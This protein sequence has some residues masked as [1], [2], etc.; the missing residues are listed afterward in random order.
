VKEL[1]SFG[2]K[3]LLSLSK[4]C[5]NG[6]AT[7]LNVWQMFLVH[8]GGFIAGFGLSKQLKGHRGASLLHWKS[9]V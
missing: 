8:I 2:I 9:Y 7:L 5:G 3:L 1:P 6:D 4:L